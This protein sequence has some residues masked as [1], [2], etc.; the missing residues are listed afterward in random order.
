MVLMEKPDLNKQK[1]MKIL[2]A[3]VVIVLIGTLI[4]IYV[5]KSGL[6]PRGSDIYGHLFRSNLMYENL[7][8]GVIYP[9]YTE[10]WYNGFQPFRYS[11]PLSYY[12]VGGLQFL[13]ADTMDSY[14]VFIAVSFIL[15]AF[16]WLIFGW[17][18]NRI[19]LCTI[20]GCLWFFLPDNAR[21]FFSEGNLPRMAAAIFIPYFFFALWQYLR[22]GK[23]RYLLMAI[24][25]T[26]L[27]TLSHIMI[28]AF[29]GIACFIF[30]MTYGIANKK[31]KE[32]FYLLS[33]MLLGLAVIGVWL[34]PALQGGIMQVDSS[35]VASYMTQKASITL[36]PFSRMTLG[37]DYFYFGTSIL[38]ISLIGLLLS[39]RICL[40]GFLAPIMFFFG[41]TTAVLPIIAK[42]P[43]GEL[44]WMMRF[45][46]MVT[47]M[48]FIAIIE[49]K[50]CRRAV[51]CFFCFLLILDS[52][53]SL[54]FVSAAGQP[55]KPAEEWQE[56][57][58]I[59]YG[60]DA[61]KELTSQ[62]LAYIDGDRTGSYPS[63]GICAAD[64]RVKYAFGWNFQ[65]ATTGMNLVQLNTAVES[66]AFLYLFDRALEM[67]N[68]TVLIR[69]D[70]IP[71]REGTFDSLKRSADKLGYQLEK[72]TPECYLFHKVTPQCFGVSTT[73]EGITIG[74]S[75]TQ[76]SLVYP[77]Y[78]KGKSDNLSDYTFKELSAYKKLYLS[79]FNYDDK[80]KAE[81]LITKLA[82]NGTIVYIDMN[83][84]PEDPKTKR[85]TFLD[86][87]AQPVSFQ[88]QFPTLIY[89][90]QKVNA[91]LFKVDYDKWNTVFL[92]NVTHERGYSY[93]E[94]KKL[95]FFGTGINNNIRFLGFNLLYHAMEAKDDKVFD[96]LDDMLG[97]NED[98]LP[99]REIIPIT[100]EYGVKGLTVDSPQ[101]NVNTTLAYLDLFRSENS[102][103]SY[104][105]LLVVDKGVTSIDFIN[106]FKTE[107]IILT[108]LG[109]LGTILLLILLARRE[110]MTKTL[111][112]SG[113]SAEPEENHGFLDE[114]DVYLN[115]DEAVEK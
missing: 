47:A 43:M 93:L 61:A 19:F 59:L 10:Y 85:M 25:L 24:L 53:P 56:E 89:K 15:G 31:W 114:L 94:N 14:L 112:N 45:V 108:L 102:L 46:P 5:G 7:K 73:Y 96:L 18:T 88:A 87:E 6:Y 23:K 109:S 51:V 3:A 75:A 8:E 110:K 106:P 78:G 13:T 111:E 1:M 38:I 64:P 72:T 58:E 101:E 113:N 115:I 27:I 80:N 82:R 74:S 71:K 42:L 67:G 21:I 66:G 33:A 52:A 68:D 97:L 11:A 100:I 22:Q 35:T 83:R 20:F 40:P 54:H 69:K 65:A 104:D 103:R 36:N 77:Y 63:Y 32:P 50:K 84:I 99:H 17:T 91:E 28:G 62:R 39:N 49:W 12:I 60:I 107:G 105:N 9:A 2:A 98:K 29:L 57:F 30:L 92:Q 95:T 4:S 76:I 79:G 26:S 55:I 16:G 86:V 34:Y 90:K 48:F 44:M 37:W 70:A 41:T 81:E